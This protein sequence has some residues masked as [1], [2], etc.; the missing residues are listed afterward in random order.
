MH[1]DGEQHEIKAGDITGVFPGGTHGLENNSNEDMH[2]I[3]FSVKV[4]V[5]NK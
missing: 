3:V 1:L 4:D 5:D 2:I